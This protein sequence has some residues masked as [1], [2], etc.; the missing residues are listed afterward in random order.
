MPVVRARASTHAKEAKGERAGA[1]NENAIKP[2]AIKIFD[3]ITRDLRFLYFV[4]CLLL[5]LLLLL[6]SPVSGW[7]VLVLVQRLYI[8]RTYVYAEKLNLLALIWLQLSHTLCAHTA[9]TFFGWV[10]CCIVWAL[11]VC[12]FVLCFF[13]AVNSAINK[14]ATIR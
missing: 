1:T 12:V 3:S 14:R 6:F 10:L 4:W 9:E 8:A 7:L 5:P 11:L 13:S 2:H